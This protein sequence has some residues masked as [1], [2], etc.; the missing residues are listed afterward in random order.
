[1]S[2]TYRYHNE[3][4]RTEESRTHSRNHRFDGHKQAELVN[5]LHLERNA[6]QL[7]TRRFGRNK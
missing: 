5:H 2:R 7:G 4:G 6:G 1:M 3:H